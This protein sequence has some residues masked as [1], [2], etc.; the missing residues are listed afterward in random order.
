MPEPRCWIGVVSREHV[1]YGV[2]NGIAQ[3]N[4]GKRE[5]LLRMH[6][7]DWLIYYSPRTSYPDGE[8]LQAFTAIGQITSP[9]PY[10]AEMSADFHPYRLD[11]T[12]LACRETPIK[13]LLS[14]LS[15]IP[16]PK[17]WGAAFRFGQVSISRA[18]FERIAAAM[19]ANLPD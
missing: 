7:G 18:D 1:L 17:H 10:Q 5:P 3:L 6:A 12:Y 14:Q 15:F 11:V 2:A 9:A 13:E 19:G 8:P 16:D 4:H